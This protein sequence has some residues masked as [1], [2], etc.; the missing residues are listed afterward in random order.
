MI[1]TNLRVASVPADSATRC[2]RCNAEIPANSLTMQG[3]LVTP[4][5]YPYVDQLGLLFDGTRNP[6]RTSW[7]HLACAV[8]VFP[9]ETARALAPDP[10]RWTRT[11]DETRALA[12]A[13]ARS[14]AIAASPPTPVEPARDPLGRPRVTVKMAG[15]ATTAESIA[16]M[17]LEV[18]AHDYAHSSPKREYVFEAVR[19]AFSVTTVRDPS[20]PIIAAVIAA[21]V[22]KATAKSQRDKFAA[23]YSLGVATPVLW[24][25]GP[26]TVEQRDARVIELR[27]LLEVAGF[28]ADL[29]PV[30]TTDRVDLAALDQLVLALDEGAGGPR[31]LTDEEQLS[32]LVASLEAALGDA[33]AAAIAVRAQR[34]ARWTNAQLRAKRSP[35][36][37]PTLLSE[38]LRA[39]TRSLALRC[40]RAPEAR[41]DA[42]DVLWPLRAQEDQATL[43]DL[44]IELLEQRSRARARVWQGVLAAARDRPRAGGGRA[45]RGV[46]SQQ[47]ISAATGRARRAD[48]DQRRDRRRG[49]AARSG[50]GTEGRRCSRS[51]GARHANRRSEARAT[52]AVTAL[53]RLAATAAL[54]RTERSRR[55]LR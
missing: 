44:L 53:S 52:S 33:D 32:G 13:T 45:D 17:Q 46:L 51:A 6:T 47:A 54:V 7:F 37:P 30:V 38:A 16:W 48:E 26:A 42:L 55:G 2:Y 1:S 49:A 8:D 12:L 25:I 40:L 43:F 50:Q 20:R 18:L 23:M 34:L 19:S 15:S 14:S 22:D 35:D 27:A 11:D 4:V 36:E 5:G 28:A 39:Q 9:E 24:I 3:L 29:A 10:I 21:T 41:D 31:S